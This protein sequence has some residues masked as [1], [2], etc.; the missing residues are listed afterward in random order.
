MTIGSSDQ[1]FGRVVIDEDGIAQRPILLF[2]GAP[3]R[4]RWQEITAWAVSDQVNRV[5][6]TGAERIDRRVLE[7]H[8]A[9]KI[10]FIVRRPDDPAFQQI[11]D[12]VRRRLP[13]KQTESLLARVSALRQGSPGA[14][15]DGGRR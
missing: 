3:F 15:A 5:V 12:A 4:L 8:S 14:E 11:V 9:G 2:F 1:R 13:D 10:H 6:K 7:L